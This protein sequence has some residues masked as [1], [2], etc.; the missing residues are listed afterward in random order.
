MKYIH[1]RRYLRICWRSIKELF[2][3]GINWRKTIVFNF[4]ML[5]YDIA[6]HLPIFLYGK[7]DISRCTGKIEFIDDK[8][9]SRGCWII[10]QSA[11][12]VNGIDACYN[13]TQLA[14]EGIL[15]LGI[16]GRIANGCR[17]SVL[18]GARLSCGDGFL[19]NADSKISCYESITIGDGVHISWEGQIYDTDFH[20]IISNDGIVKRRNK[21]I[22]IGNDAWIGHNVTICKGAVIGDGCIVAAHSLL[23]KDFSEY[24]NCIFA[25]TPA[26]LI[27]TGYKR[28]YDIAWEKKIAAYFA[29]N[30]EYK[31]CTMNNEGIII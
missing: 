4:R 10:G 9:I 2:F 15:R 1:P 31:Q 11:C 25:G 27:R 23:N 19:L 30:N 8:T 18:K 28:I 21:S 26:V 24:K 20:Y 22:L 12:I 16:S 13:V 29:L 6:K 5:P 14:V 7:V 17:I 3:S